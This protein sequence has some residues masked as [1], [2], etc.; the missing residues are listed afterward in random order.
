[1]Y[2]LQHAD[3]PSLYAG[4]PDQPAISPQVAFWKGGFKR[5][6]MLGMGAALLAGMFHFVSRGPNEVTDEDEA[7]AAKL[8]EESDHKEAA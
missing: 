5:W 8:A 1:M 2:V 7:K 4:L 3:R 6:S